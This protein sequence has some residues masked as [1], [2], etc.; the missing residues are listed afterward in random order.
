MQIAAASSAPTEE[1]VTLAEY[2]ES[3][4]LTASAGGEDTLT[5]NLIAARRWAE[6]YTG[7]AFIPRNYQMVVTKKPDINT[8]YLQHPPVSAVAS[9]TYDGGK[10][11]S[12]DNYAFNQFLS[13]LTLKTDKE[14]PEF[15]D[16]LVINYTAGYGAAADVPDAIKRAIIL[17]A[18]SF[19][20]A[21]KLQAAQDNRGLA[22]LR[23]SDKAAADAMKLLY[24]FRVLDRLAHA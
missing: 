4:M 9:V 22:L 24:P 3:N 13:A 20:K 23:G 21:P 11:Y 19:E 17:V 18:A 15:T 8:I 2:R 12:A 5:M 10:A 16:S 7:R 14:W 6:E 1:P